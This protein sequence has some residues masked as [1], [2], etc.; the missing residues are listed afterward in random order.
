[1]KKVKLKTVHEKGKIVQHLK[2]VH[3][4]GKIVETKDVLKIWKLKIC[5]GWVIKL[6]KTGQ[7]IK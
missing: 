5:Y 2:T 6:H 3:E 4:K 7:I 1:M